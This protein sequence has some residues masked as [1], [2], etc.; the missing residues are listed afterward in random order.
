[1][2][3]LSHLL[4]LQNTEGNSTEWKKPSL[5]V[6]VFQWQKLTTVT[7]RSWTIL[8]FDPSHLLGSKIL[9]LGHVPGYWLWGCPSQMFL[10]LRQIFRTNCFFHSPFSLSCPFQCAIRPNIFIR[11]YVF[12]QITEIRNQ[13]GNSTTK[14]IKEYKRVLGKIVCSWIG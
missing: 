13:S 8:A 3:C 10:E 12:S 11:C 5:Q 7:Y 14:S 6:T 9:I 4:W 2:D 1:M